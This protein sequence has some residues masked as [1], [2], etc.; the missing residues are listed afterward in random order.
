M[1]LRI[2][3]DNAYQTLELDAK[4]T[5]Q[6]W[7]SL[8]LEGEGLTQ[9]EREVLIQRTFEERFNRPDYNSWHKLDRHRGNTKA[10][11]GKDEHEDDV[12]TSEPLMDEVFDNRIFRK[13]ELDREENESYDAICQWVRETLSKKPTWAEAFISVRMDAKTVNDYA[14]SISVERPSRISHWLKR[15][16]VKLRE[17]FPKNGF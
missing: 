9:K 2:R 5:E 12:N 16:E 7:F 15:A 8:D 14:S 13:D 6:L 17:H 10:K 4:E 3:Y 11:P 1:K